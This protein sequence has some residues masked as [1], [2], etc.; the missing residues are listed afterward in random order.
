MSAR[1]KPTVPMG[2]N[3]RYD[4]GS[5]NT[6]LQKD[7]TNLLTRYD[8]VAF[9][10]E[11][12]IAH[13][14][15]A[16]HDMLNAYARDELE[17]LGE[18]G[19]RLL[20]T[21]HSD[22]VLRRGLEHEFEQGFPFIDVTGKVGRYLAIIDQV[23]A[24]R[25]VE[26]KRHILFA[27]LPTHRFNACV[28]PTPNGLLCLMNTGL[29]KLLYHI[30][31]AAFYALYGEPSTEANVSVPA[32]TAAAVSIIRI[33]HNYLESKPFG[34][35]AP[36]GFSIDQAAL[37]DATALCYS[38]RVF[39][40][41]HEIGH[42]VLGHAD[43]VMDC[44]LRGRSICSA[45]NYE[46]EFD[47]DS[48]AQGILLEI[49]ECHFFPEPTAGGG[50]GFLMIHAMLLEVLAKLRGTSLEVEST[51]STHPPTWDRI[52][53]INGLLKDYYEKCDSRVNL[54]SCVVLQR[55]LIVIQKAKFSIINGEFR[56]SFS[57]STL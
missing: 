45:D 15:Q 38:I 52:K 49:D 18:H 4:P 48:F 8:A 29:L 44:L 9:D 17:L 39:V 3:R 31:V 30:C 2:I 35:A 42:I 21:I 12:A 26:L 16:M 40:L 11:K 54:S 13:Q 56:V 32:E 27:E 57:P 50:L 53:K 33:I 19:A 20:D 41:A 14:R 47:A 34:H 55:M 7:F 37:Y 36:V 51:S 6:R 25:G 23:L 5:V 10:H 1:L 24:R 28:E 22:P 43:D 46:G